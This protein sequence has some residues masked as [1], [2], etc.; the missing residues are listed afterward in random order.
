MDD[1]DREDRL[2]RLVERFYE[3][4]RRD[5]LLGPIFESA[6][7]DWPGHFR[8]VA[9]FWSHALF[10]TGRYRG[11]PFP[12]HMRLDFPAEAFDRWLEV[13][14]RAATEILRPMEAEAALGRARHMTQSFRVGLFPYTLPDGRPSRRPP[15]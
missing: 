12:A 11:H 9:D 7:H 3:L 8:V 10:G 4:G 2:Y 13:F 15:Q 14:E 5:A 6:I 1:D